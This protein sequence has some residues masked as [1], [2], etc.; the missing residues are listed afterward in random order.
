MNSNS[1]YTTSVGVLSFLVGT[2]SVSLVFAD[3][4][5]DL[6]QELLA[7]DEYIDPYS[8]LN[9]NRNLSNERLLLRLQQ[10]VAGKG[11]LAILEPPFVVL[12]PGNQ[13]DY[14]RSNFNGLSR[15][16]FSKTSVETLIG[17]SPAQVQILSGGNTSRARALET[18]IQATLVDHIQKDPDVIRTVI[19]RMFSTRSSN[20]NRFIAD[21]QTTADEID[22][23]FS[24]QSSRA[25]DLSAKVGTLKRYMSE[26]E[27]DVARLR[28]VAEKIG[29]SKREAWAIEEIIKETEPKNLTEFL[30]SSRAIKIVSSHESLVKALKA[31]EEA[32]DAIRYGKANEAAN[33]RI[34]KVL[35]EAARHLEEAP[36]AADLTPDKMEKLFPVSFRYI[37]EELQS[38][39]DL[40]NANKRLRSYFGPALRN[41]GKTFAGIS[42]AVAIAANANA[43]VDGLSDSGKSGSSTDFP[44]DRSLSGID[45]GSS[46][47][48]VGAR[49]DPN[50]KGVF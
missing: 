1:K 3:P 37:R 27:A 24:G 50:I 14:Q 10:K 33:V 43:R 11:R 8:N 19:D 36:R 16:S 39:F 44:E 42:L 12:G 26:W 34:L 4:Q 9:Q 38:N 49:R 48:S 31:L 22:Q 46:R 45:G 41:V 30:K 15:L 28:K 6:R 29:S 25:R 2:F 21:A 47:S 13:I 32:K 18:A 7:I 35:N 23:N 20:I 40:I 17:I 5:A